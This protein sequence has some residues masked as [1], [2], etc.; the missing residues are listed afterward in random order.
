MVMTNHKL[1]AI[2]LSICVDT[3]NYS[4]CFSNWGGSITSDA[5]QKVMEKLEDIMRDMNVEII[6]EK[7]SFTIDADTGL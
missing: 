1:S 7:P 3:L 2:D 5:R 4:L 6:T